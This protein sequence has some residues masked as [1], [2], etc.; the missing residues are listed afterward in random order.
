MRIFFCWFFIVW[1]FLY[2]ASVSTTHIAYILRVRVAKWV[3]VIYDRIDRLSGHI[4]R[5][6]WLHTHTQSIGHICDYYIPRQV[7]SLGQLVGCTLPT[8][9]RSLMRPE[10]IAY[11]DNNKSNPTSTHYTHTHTSHIQITASKARVALRVLSLLSRARAERGLELY[12]LGLRKG[13]SLDV[14]RGRRLL[15]H[16][17]FSR[18]KKACDN[19]VWFVCVLRRILLFNF[20]Y[21][22]CMYIYLHRVDRWC[23][24][25]V[26]SLGWLCPCRRRHRHMWVK[27]I[28]CAHIIV[29]CVVMRSVVRCCVLCLCWALRR[30]TRGEWL[31]LYGRNGLSWLRQTCCDRSYRVLK[32]AQTHIHR[33]QRAVESIKQG[34]CVRGG[35]GG[36]KHNGPQRRTQ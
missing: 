16:G 5:T 29:L 14:G 35:C 28:C 18:P 22:V 34:L 26:Y 12:F 2:A 33:T 32:G 21:V 4:M 11:K 1:P 6:T 17:R 3:L 27:R 23:V 20:F 19:Q 7:K 25:I 10:K 31:L 15:H 8:P 30:E 24:Y 9:P 36:D 13:S